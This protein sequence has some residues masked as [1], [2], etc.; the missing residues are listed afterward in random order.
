MIR[1]QLTQAEAQRLF[2]YRDGMLYWRHAGSGHRSD[3][4]A[5]TVRPQSAHNKKQ[6][7]FVRIG[8]LEYQAHYLIWNWHNGLTSGRITVDGVSL[9]V[10]NLREVGGNFIV[11]QSWEKS[12]CP[13]CSQRVPVPILD[14]IAFNSGLQ[15]LE[16][17]V[18][19]AVWDGKGMPVQTAR[20]IDAMYGDDEDG[21][22]EQNRA[23]QN[24]K[25][26]MTRLRGKLNG[27]GIGVVNCGYGAGYRLVMGAVS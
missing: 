1:N 17:K 7:R 21:G 3:Q 23:Y 4:K 27:T 14:V 5:I 18:L 26:A 6:E 15:P 19:R 25:I 22:P 24:M 13:C 12:T 10:E 8:G 11:G 16:K 2:D 20:I 9:A